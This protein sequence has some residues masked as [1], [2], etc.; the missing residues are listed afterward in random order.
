MVHLKQYA[1]E[2]WNENNSLSEA[3]AEAMSDESNDIVSTEIKRLSG[4]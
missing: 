2:K 3:H 1:T 4:V